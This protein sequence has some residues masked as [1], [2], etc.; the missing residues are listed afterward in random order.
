MKERLLRLKDI[1]L[2][3]VLVETFN[4]W[5]A[6]KVGR[7]AGALAFFS[8]LSLAPLLLIT[9]SVLGLVTD[10][11]TV[12]GEVYETL[13]DV[14]GQR[15]ADLVQDMVQSINQTQT[16]GIAALVGV[17]TLLYGA[18]NVFGQLQEALNTVWNVDIKPDQ[19]ILRTLKRRLW[20]VI[21]L[22]VTGVVVL[23]SLVIDTALT[24]VA[25]F[26]GD[27]IPHLG[28]VHLLQVMSL[29]V[30][31]LII[32]F[33]FAVIYKYLP[34]VD[35]EW[36]DVFAGAAVTALLFAIGQ[37]LLSVYLTRG[38]VSSAYGAA[39]TFMVVLLWV[40]YSAQIFLFGA[41]LTQVFVRRRGKR[42]RPS[43]YAYH[44]NRLPERFQEST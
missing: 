25:H 29:T 21:M 43:S 30:F 24:A 22:P 23:A 41:E 26:L 11:H 17:L 40:Y 33:L 9:V 38:S 35:I 14:V 32:T 27:Q 10:Q 16:G 4:Q 44:V 19:G 37:F 8:M 31:V 3:S 1:A 34:D 13:T 12:E 7:V 2:V 39:G 42:I 15:S 18:I 6:D 5:Q 20:A 36:E 28:Y